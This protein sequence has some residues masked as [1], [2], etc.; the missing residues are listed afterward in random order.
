[1]KLKI[2]LLVIEH[3]SWGRAVPRSNSLDPKGVETSQE[4]K[5]TKQNN[6]IVTAISPE[7]E[8][9]QANVFC[10]NRGTLI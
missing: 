2:S 7:V 6:K 5:H 10:C 9:N 1:M 3:L 8:P 4:H